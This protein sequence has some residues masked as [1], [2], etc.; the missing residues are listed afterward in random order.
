M[1]SVRTV[2]VRRTADVLKRKIITTVS[3]RF[4]AIKRCNSKESCRMHASYTCLKKTRFERVRRNGVKARPLS[5]DRPSTFPLK[6]IKRT[7]TKRAALWRTYLS[8]SWKTYRHRCARSWVLP[9]V[10]D[11][12]SNFETRILSFISFGMTKRSELTQV[13]LAHRSHGGSKTSQR[14]SLYIVHECAICVGWPKRFY[15]TSGLHSNQSTLTG[16]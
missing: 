9:S 7:H 16:M 6:Q 4:V 11:G 8:R 13:D 10:V 14:C 3:S 2:A 12:C 1:A 15:W 5:H